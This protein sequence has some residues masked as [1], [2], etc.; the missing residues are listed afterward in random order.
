MRGMNGPRTILVAATCSEARHALTRISRHAPPK[1]EDGEKCR[2][3]AHQVHEVYFPAMPP[4]WE[5]CGRMSGDPIFSMPLTPD[6]TPQ[7]GVVYRFLPAHGT[8]AVIRSARAGML[9]EPVDVDRWPRSASLVDA[10]LHDP[11]T[12]DTHRIDGSDGAAALFWIDRGTLGLALES[13]DGTYRLAAC[14]LATGEL[15][16]VW[17]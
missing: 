9:C 1:P 4:D 8:E 15:G 11:Q 5:P 10:F 2:R 17:R 6:T 16:P 13:E 12:G 3:A 7:D 14:A